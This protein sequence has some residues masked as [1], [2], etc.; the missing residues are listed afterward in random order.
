MQGGMSQFFY[1]SPSSNFMTTFDIS[2]PKQDNG[3]ILCQNA[4]NSNNKR[5]T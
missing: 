1:F 3:D 2:K 4:T 5:N